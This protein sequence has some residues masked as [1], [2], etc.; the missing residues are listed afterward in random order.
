VDPDTALLRR[1]A[2]FDSGW[3][4]NLIMEMNP[5]S[6]LAP[7]ANR[8][9]SSA[10][11]SNL[12]IS[13]MEYRRTVGPIGL[14]NRYVQGWAVGSNPRCSAILPEYANRYSGCAFTAVFAGSSPVSGAKPRSSSGQGCWVLSSVTRVRISYGV[15][16]FG[17]CAFGNNRHPSGRAL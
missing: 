14:E 3:G 7:T 11:S 5:G 1:L 16:G 12:L 10:C 9:V 17:G 2:Q 6:V 4:R 13:A 15:R 8:V